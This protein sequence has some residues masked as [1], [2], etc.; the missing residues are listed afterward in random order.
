MVLGLVW[1]L[2]GVL[3]STMFRGASGHFH[4]EP[5]AN[6]NCLKVD[7]WCRLPIDAQD[8][9][10]T[11]SGWSA[12]S[13]NSV[14]GGFRVGSMIK[15]FSKKS[16]TSQNIYID[17]LVCSAWKTNLQGNSNNLHRIIVDDFTDSMTYLLMV[18]APRKLFAS[19]HPHTGKLFT[20]SSSYLHLCNIGTIPTLQASHFNTDV[21]NRAGF[22]KLFMG[23]S[24][25]MWARGKA[26]ITCI[27]SFSLDP[28]NCCAVPKHKQQNCRTWWS[29]CWRGEARWGAAF[30]WKYNC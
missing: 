19:V 3:I 11:V 1:T 5:K 17:A 6:A 12:G 25:K 27:L 4:F 26:R 16:G 18:I 20:A 22:S 29:M 23:H 28:I 13:C 24:D 14:Y 2:E 9:C 10:D 30:R 8:N 7:G 15:I 21:V